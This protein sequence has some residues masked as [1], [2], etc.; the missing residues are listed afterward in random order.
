MTEYNIAELV[1]ENYELKAR[2][3]ELNEVI[4]KLNL[5]LYNSSNETYIPA[6]NQRTLFCDFYKSG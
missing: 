2:M 6:I 1:K 3:N 4:V 5:Q